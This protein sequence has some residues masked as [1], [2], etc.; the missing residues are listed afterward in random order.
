MTTYASPATAMAT[1]PRANMS[2]RWTRNAAQWTL[3]VT[4]LAAVSVKIAK[5]TPLE[6]TASSANL[7]S[8]AHP[9]LQKLILANVS[10]TRME[11]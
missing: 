5:E 1:R 4:M 3:A 9:T 8:G 6:I 10:S 2:K 7:A 11:K